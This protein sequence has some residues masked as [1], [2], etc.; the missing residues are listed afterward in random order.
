[1]RVRI[2]GVT[3][4]LKL[5]EEY[6]RNSFTPLQITVLDY[7]SKRNYVHKS[8]RGIKLSMKINIDIPSRLKAKNSDT[9]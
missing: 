5:L 8:Q 7:Y 2:D 6:R 4:T 9:N 3:F 1:M